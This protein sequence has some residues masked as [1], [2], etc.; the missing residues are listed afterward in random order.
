MKKTY[1][2]LTLTAFIILV[3]AAVFFYQNS[4]D[5][6]SIKISSNPWVGFTPFIY[7]QE[8]GWLDKTPFKFMWLVDLSD[9]A[10]LYDR[11][12]TQGFTATQY[13]LLR[14]KEHSRLKPVFLID[15]S[16]GADAILS[17]RP[18]SELST[19]NEPITVYL[20][21]G[22]LDE[23]FFNAFIHENKLEKLKFILKN[24]SQKT[25]TTVS[26]SGSAVIMISYAPYVSEFL[27]KGYVTVAST[28]SMKSFF[29][30]DALYVDER[31]VIG[32][33]KQY[34]ELLMIF[35]KALQQFKK[36]PHEYYETIRGY[37]EGQSYED[38]MDTTTKIQ[39]L[40]SGIH[41]DVEAQL[42]LQ[43][44]SIDRLLR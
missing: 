38:F 41:K 34:R 32:R 28:R 2:I 3:V 9:N 21:L 40:N 31:F 10:R 15:R 1:T 33:E 19:A 43:N 14:F 23:D 4:S 20:E 26:P 37:L 6:Q 44:V 36:D 35:N 17:N 25:M 29:V 22:S 42:Y 27:K 18:L 7:A 12:F 5:K 24:S 39:W 11:G 13:E 8:K 30:I 16:Y